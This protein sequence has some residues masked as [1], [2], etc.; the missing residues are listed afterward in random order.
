MSLQAV[1]TSCILNWGKTFMKKYE[2]IS[3]LQVS[4]C[5]GWNQQQ[6]AH[7]RRIYPH[8]VFLHSSVISM[9][10]GW[11]VK[12]QS[13]RRPPSPG[14]LRAAQRHEGSPVDGFP[15]RPIEVNRYIPRV[16]EKMNPWIVMNRYSTSTLCGSRYKMLWTVIWNYS[17]RT[18]QHQMVQRRYAKHSVSNDTQ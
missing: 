17:I 7:Q 12:H 14:Q 8:L 11:R 18:R 5:P 15:T 10:S 2:N 3:I 13:S 1:I 9:Y 6:K 16:T 4:D